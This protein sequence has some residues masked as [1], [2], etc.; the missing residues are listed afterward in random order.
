MIVFETGTKAIVPVIDCIVS[1]PQDAT[2]GCGARVME[3][4]AGIAKSFAPMPANRLALRIRQ[5]FGD[6]RI[7]I[8]RD[9][10][11]RES[12]EQGWKGV[13][14]KCSALSAYPSVFCMGND[15][16]AFFFKFGHRRMFIKLHAA[17]E[18]SL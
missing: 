14:G 9:Y 4:P 15:M 11:I 1:A 17:L 10:I 12:L 8:D 6:N 3:L 7:V 16:I 2:V 18:T 13:R 5:R